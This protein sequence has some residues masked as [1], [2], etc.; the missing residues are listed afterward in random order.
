MKDLEIVFK[1]KKTHLKIGGEGETILIL[2][3]WQS[4]SETWKKVIEILEKKLRVICPDL[5]GF[6]KS[7]SL[8]KKWKIKDYVEWL[9][10]FVDYFNLNNFYLFGHS[11]GGKLAIKFSFENQTRIKCLLLCSPS[12]I[13][14]KLG[15]NQKFIVFLAKFSNFLFPKK[16]FGN[17][18]EFLT[19]VFCFLF[20]RNS[21]YCKAK[22]VIRETFKEIIKE[23]VFSQISNFNLKTVIFWGK[24]DKITPVEHAF[25]LKQKIK[26]SKLEILEGLGH[27]P[28]LEDPE[29][30]CRI[31]VENLE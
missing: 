13:R 22:G 26:N 3:G 20:L 18:R 2:H 1:G 29:R 28:H 16:F 9:E 5:P 15:I 10:D 4:S 30:F 14:P 8:E 7:F 17:L 25:L 12:V 31:L 21:D 23:D 27:S 11:F 19:N 6:G 24:N